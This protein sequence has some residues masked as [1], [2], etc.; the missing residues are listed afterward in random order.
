MKRFPFVAVVLALSAVVGSGQQTATRYNYNA[1]SVMVI[2]AGMQALLTCNGLFVS[3]RTLDQLYSAE[4]KLVPSLAPPSAVKIDP[5]RK[6][7][8]VGDNVRGLGLVMRAA[9]R[10]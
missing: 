9:Y 5:E 8:A 7:V 3:N 6:T 2:N 1:S 10:E 4:L